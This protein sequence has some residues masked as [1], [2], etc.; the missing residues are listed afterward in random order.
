MATVQYEGEI[1]YELNDVAIV[2]DG[3]IKAEQSYTDYSEHH[4]SKRT[5]KA[6][7]RAH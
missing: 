5:G 1:Q 7:V 2:V 3:E 6:L 4:Y